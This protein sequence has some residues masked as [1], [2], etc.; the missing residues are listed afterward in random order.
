MDRPDKLHSLQANRFVEE[1]QAVILAGGLGTRMRPITNTIP[2]PM[3]PVL[4]KP[5]LQWQIELLTSFGLQRILLLVGHDGEHIKQHFAARAPA[6]C[7]ISYSYEEHPLGTGGALKNAES[8]LEDQFILLNGDTYLA[9]DYRALI[10]RFTISGALSLIVAY[11]APSH[12]TN[13]A[14][15]NNLAVE[16]GHVTSYRKRNP[17][18]LTHTDA[19]VILLRK[20]ILAQIPPGEPCSLEEEIFPILIA[21]GDMQAAITSE[22]FYD[23]G[24]PAGLA[25]FAA[26]HT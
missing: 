8:Q 23:I 4:D 21:N 18:G 13:Q 2:K 16:R 17:V 10:R 19:G 6:H 24:T 26:R 1:F 14:V 15:A 25:S 9:I 3:I 20:K 7:D 11:E 5:F 22:P 12:S